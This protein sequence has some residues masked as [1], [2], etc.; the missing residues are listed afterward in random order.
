[1]AKKEKKPVSK[2][3][4]I[5]RWTFIGSVTLVL[6]V[7]TIFV[8]SVSNNLPP[9]NDIENPQLDL[10]TRIYTA[11]GK[12]LGTFHSAENRV[13]IPLDSMS[14]W[15]KPALMASEDIRFENHSGIDARV[16][17]T[18]IK[19]L[20]I[21]QRLRG[22]SSI[23]QQL[24]RNLYNQVGKENSIGRKVKEA[25]VAVILESRFTKDEIMQAYLNTTCFYGT[26]Y[27]IEMGAQTLFSKS[28]ADLELH[29]AA[30]LIGM[31][32]NPTYYSPTR[33]E[34]RA[35]NC[36]N[37]V[38]DQVSKYRSELDA[39][40]PHLK[41][42]QRKIQEA[43]DKSLEL[44]VRAGGNTRNIA[45]YFRN[46][47]KRDVKGILKEK[48]LDS[49]YDLFTDGLKVYTTLD[50]RMQRYAE[51]AV[52]EHLSQLQ[53]TFLSEF[54]RTGEPW[55][56]NSKILK[57]AMRQSE[58]WRKGKKAG[59]RTKE[60][61][62]SFDKPAKMRLWTWDGAVDTTLTPKDSLIHYLTFLQTGF[63]SMDPHTG[64]VKA[65][66]GG[67]DYGH[68]KLDHVRQTKRQVG[69]TFKPIVYAAGMKELHK[70]CDQVLDVPVSISLPDGKVWRPRNSGG[71]DDGLISYYEGLSRSKNQVTAYLMKELG[72]K[73]V[74]EYAEALGVTSELECVPSLCLG[75]SSLTVYEMTSVYSSFVNSGTYTEPYLVSRIED[76]TG[77]V[78]YQH[79]PKIHEALD[80]ET[81][82]TMVRMLQGVVDHLKGTGHRLRTKYKFQNQ[83]GGK[84][85]TTQNNTDGW[86]MGVTPDL[87]SGVWVGCDDSRLRF[88]RTYYGQG[89][90]MALPI[91]AIYMKYIYADDEIGLSEDP[92][93]TPEG[94][95]MT[96][97]CPA[98]KTKSFWEP[99]DDGDPGDYMDRLDGG[100]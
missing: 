89:A 35:R 47:V 15:V 86:F 28:A 100:T 33:N 46:Q 60:I 22:G 59:L 97:F 42:T 19:D 36:R 7:S 88:R 78:L 17:F 18:I 82:F 56:K 34:E 6:L 75:T 13:F 1:M 67:I 76:K 49:K 14:P 96:P 61:E 38:L 71:K 30:L 3:A 84:T 83:I 65:W 90:N 55:K 72:P 63:M 62:E 12:I 23:T 81:A 26:S 43:R 29:E 70:P 68:F 52:R 87:V 66:V 2:V 77:R 24:A 64:E 25:I 54:K 50:S 94:Y 48:G 95:R 32:K 85:G 91:F 44:R 11:D 99:G 79:V 98:P 80:P 31:L 92:F 37:T 20:I 57:D 74:C 41:L 5:F 27:G 53:K 93:P 69:S 73:R 45:P 40:F 51:K 16:P 4:K 39:Q 8:I 58:R 9:M 21:K 10:S